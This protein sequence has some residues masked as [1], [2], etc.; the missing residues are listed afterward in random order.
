[1]CI[2][3][4]LSSR[5]VPSGRPESDSSSA[6]VAADVSPV[7]Q[8]HTLSSFES[9]LTQNRFNVLSQEESC[10]VSIPTPVHHFIGDD[11]DNLAGDIARCDA[12]LDAIFF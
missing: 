1:L 10:D 9:I 5:D 2:A 7:V 6:P 3:K 12:E 8:S 4:K 11:T